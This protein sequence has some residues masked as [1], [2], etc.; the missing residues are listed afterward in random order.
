VIGAQEDIGRD[1]SVIAGLMGGYRR[2]E[3]EDDA[4]ARLREAQIE[5]L[6]LMRRPKAVAA[7]AH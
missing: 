6:A 5:A 2:F 7:A 3:P 1:L 4:P